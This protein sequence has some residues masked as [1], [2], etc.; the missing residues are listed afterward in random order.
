MADNRPDIRDFST[1]NKERGPSVASLF[2]AEAERRA[3]ELRK[4]GW[5]FD[6]IADMMNITRAAASRAVQT[7]LAN[8]RKDCSELAEDVVSMELSRLDELLIVAQALAKAGNLEA[9][10]RVLKIQERRAKYLG[11][12][13][14]AK[15]QISVES[16][17]IQLRGMSLEDLDMLEQ[18]ASRA[19]ALQGSIEVEALDADYLA[20]ANLQLPAPIQIPREE[21]QEQLDKDP[22]DDN[23]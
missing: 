17:G 1:F 23:E 4:E 18:I 16:T 12:D 3:L 22:A 6:Q 20:G 11:L 13:Q 15:T 9:I 8:I 14:P 10:D 2:K 5:S 7:A 21:L 19:A